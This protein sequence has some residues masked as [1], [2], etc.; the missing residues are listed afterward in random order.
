MVFS[1]GCWGLG[2]CMPGVRKSKLML[3]L[4][5]D[6]VE[7]KDGLATFWLSCILCVGIALGLDKGVDNICKG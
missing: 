4:G 5:S 1:D 2:D 6:Q 3:T 7:G